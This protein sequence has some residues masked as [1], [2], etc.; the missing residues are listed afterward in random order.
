MGGDRDQGPYRRPWGAVS[1]L[2]LGAD[3]ERTGVCEGGS[4]TLTLGFPA[5]RS[6]KIPDAFQPQPVV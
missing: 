3:R 2:P 5:P 4:S 1:P 6:V